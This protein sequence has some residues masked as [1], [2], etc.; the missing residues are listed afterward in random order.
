MIFQASD[1]KRNH[2]LDLLD[3]KLHIIEPLYT[4][5]HSWINQFDHSNLLCA[6]ATRAI[7][8]HTPIREYVTLFQLNIPCTNN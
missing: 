3:D 7:T 4:K 6:K 8:N 5:E 2:F 1:L